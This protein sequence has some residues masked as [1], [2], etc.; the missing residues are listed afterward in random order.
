MFPAQITNVVSVPKL[1]DNDTE[2]VS[3]LVCLSPSNPC[4]S[5]THLKSLLLLFI[6]YNQHNAVNY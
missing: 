2:L 3:K 4:V 6:R 5:L 1:N